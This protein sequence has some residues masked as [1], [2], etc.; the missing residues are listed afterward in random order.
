MDS[1]EENITKWDLTFNTYMDIESKCLVLIKNISEIKTNLK[2]LIGNQKKDDII[3]YRSLVEN[4]F[5]YLTNSLKI[6]KIKFLKDINYV[7]NHIDKS[8]NLEELNKSN[9]TSFL[10]DYR[11]L[12]D[13]INQARKNSTALT[14]VKDDQIESLHEIEKDM[15]EIMSYHLNLINFFF[16]SVELEKIFYCGK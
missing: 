14:W 16:G 15:N 12:A 5:F 1:V 11:K 6:R 10:K 4:S 3:F 7:Y 8:K 13:D 9:F 2:K